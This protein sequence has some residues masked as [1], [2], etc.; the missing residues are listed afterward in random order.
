MSVPS[1]TGVD[2]AA[3]SL[4]QAIYEACLKSA[5]EM[6]DI[7]ELSWFGRHHAT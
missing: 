3:V 6:K 1:V 5:K 7:K 4:K 2:F